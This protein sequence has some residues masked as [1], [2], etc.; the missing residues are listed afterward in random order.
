MAGRRVIG[1]V[2][3]GLAVALATATAG[4]ESP[5][6]LADAYLSAVLDGDHAAAVALWSEADRSAATR[7]G[8]E[9]A[10]TSPKIDSA[11][12]LWLHRTDLR[13]GRVSVRVVAAE[14]GELRYRLRAGGDSLDVAYPC[15]REAAGWRLTRTETLLVARWPT[16]RTEY[17]ALIAQP[18]HDV[19]EAAL[20]RL[21]AFVD[22]TCRRLEVPPARLTRLREA[23]LGYLLCD[24]DTVEALV[25]APTVGVA[26]LQTDL[27]ITS[28]PCH[29]HELAHLL[30]NYALGDPPLYTL[31]LMQ[32]GAAVAL[33]GRWGRA[34]AVMSSLGRFALDEGFVSL[35]A[36][37]TWDDF[38]AVSADMSYAPAGLW[39]GW[40]L[41]ELGGARFLDLYRALSGPLDAVRG[42]T[43]E[44]VRARVSEAAGRSWRE[45]E[46]GFVAYLETLSC[47]GIWAVDEARGDARG[48]AL[49]GARGAAPGAARGTELVRLSAGGGEAALFVTG[50]Q[51]TWELDAPRGALVLN[52]LDA[53]GPSRLHD[54]IFPGRTRGDA[55][56]AL[57]WSPEEIGL[58]DFRTDLLLAKFVAG[59]CPGLELRPAPDRPAT[60]RIDR[61]L[62][63]A[64]VWRD[65]STD[66]P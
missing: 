34:P 10:D 25:G 63:P 46:D 44:E 5:A 20:A 38:Y 50:S 30:M 6:A 60:F 40:L 1:L 54:E 27:V 28:E 43:A 41:D 42:L 55:I 53:V 45:L 15:V 13:A 35:D 4:A 29:L 2:L 18:S 62:V 52:G 21:D 59:F 32:E 24:P 36:L 17:V 16:R 23:K 7:L 57:V 64:G 31:P 22:E 3:A 14:A 12:P 66:L 26:Q 8:L 11:S 39:A 49:V 47:G 37:L 9:Y 48:D 65:A 33:G 58:Y 56:L 51:L 19:S 61:S